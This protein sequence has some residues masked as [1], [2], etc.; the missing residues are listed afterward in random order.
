MNILI[1]GASGFIGKQLTDFLSKTHQVSVLGRDMGRLNQCF[2]D[3]TTNKLTWDNLNKHNAKQ[4][5]TII[6]LSGANIAAKRW[7]KAI[8]QE[9][10]ASRIT[11]NNKLIN[12][13]IMQEA[14]PHY[15]C[16]N[17]IG[18][19]GTHD[20][21]L[22]FD[23]NSP[24]ND[25]DHPNDFLKQIS[26]AWQKSLKPAID[27]GIKVTTLRFGIVLKK[28]EGMLKKLE[29]PFSL[30]LGGIFGDGQQII[31]WIHYTDLV[32]V[33]NFLL[34]HRDITGAINITSPNP[35]PQKDFAIVFA[36]VLNRPLFLKIPAF[37]VKI[38]LGEMGDSLI[39]KGQRVIPKRLLELNFNFT[40]PTLKQALE[41]E[42][43]KS[44]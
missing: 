16:A 6:N 44:M 17:A 11:T 32:N 2:P 13:L 24:I 37:F 9:L 15:Y 41:Q 39:L 40:Y 27:R 36:A 3:T 7:T 4:F 38:L 22:S 29:L 8:K 26:L 1:A 23:E 18:I 25:D 30:G 12:W 28:G 42:F 21:T 33:I 5:D 35:V 14:Y 34:E 20:K 19:Y 43:K 31:S 10:I